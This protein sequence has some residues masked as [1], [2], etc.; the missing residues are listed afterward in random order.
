MA[1]LARKPCT[2]WACDT[3]A[4]CAGIH[5][6]VSYSRHSNNSAAARSNWRAVTVCVRRLRSCTRSSVDFAQ[7]LWCKHCTANTEIVF[8]VAVVVQTT[9]CLSTTVL[10]ARGSEQVHGAIVFCALDCLAVRSVCRTGLFTTHSIAIAGT[11]RASNSRQRVDK[12]VETHWSMR[13]D[14]HL[15]DRFAIAV[16]NRPLFVLCR[17]KVSA[18]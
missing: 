14:N 13:N 6:Y 10:S 7:C 15:A 9:N 8:R 4:F 2:E 5:T 3:I 1:I 18:V 11:F 12:I 17:V 16:R